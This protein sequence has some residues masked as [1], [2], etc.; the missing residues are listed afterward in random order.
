MNMGRKDFD[1]AE[2]ELHS[3]EEE[4]R[5]RLMYELTEVAEGRSSLIFD[6]EVH[7]PSDLPAHM[8]PA[9]SVELLDLARRSIA[10]RKLLAV[11]TEHCIGSQFVAACE[12]HADLGNPHR[13]GAK[14]LA[15][16]LL[17]KIRGGSI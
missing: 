11:P 15:E 13:L 2:K 5:Q 16:R 8:L 10:L 1:R 7:N 6:S 14:R 3:L 12:E 4:L 17:S 9:A